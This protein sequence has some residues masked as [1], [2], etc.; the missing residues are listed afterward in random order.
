MTQQ[1]LPWQINTHSLQCVCVSVCSVCQ[2][3]VCL[4][5][6]GKVIYYKANKNNSPVRGMELILNI[7]ALICGIIGML[8]RERDDRWV[9]QSSDVRENKTVSCHRHFLYYTR[10]T[11]SPQTH[12]SLLQIMSVIFARK[13]SWS[14][15]DFNIFH[16]HTKSTIAASKFRLVVSN[17]FFSGWF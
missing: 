15:A 5:R 4:Y 9:T 7:A 6:L 17:M 14:T 8:E 10:S 2:R 11:V 12:L 1:T 3:C 16:P 13:L